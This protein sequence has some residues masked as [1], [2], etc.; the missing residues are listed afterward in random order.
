MKTG[1]REVVQ[2]RTRDYA[3]PLHVYFGFTVGFR[4]TVEGCGQD[5]YV[6]A[7]EVEPFSVGAL[8]C[9][10]SSFLAF[11]VFPSRVVVTRSIVPLQG[12]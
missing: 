4:C 6:R 2:L 1:S 10:C 5:R 7:V 11:T 8:G 9:Q 12:Y 3:Q